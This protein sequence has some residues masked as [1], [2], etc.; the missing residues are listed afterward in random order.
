M[1][2]RAR[3]AVRPGER[4]F[5]PTGVPVMA[6][7][8]HQRVV[9]PRLAR[10]ELDRPKAVLVTRGVLHA[11]LEG[12]QLAQ[13]EVIDVGVEVRR[14][15]RVMGKIWIGV[16][17]REVRVLHARARGVDE[18]VAVGGGHPVLVL[19]HPVAAHAVGLLE[20]VEGDAA[21]VQCLDRRDPGGARADQANVRQHRRA[22]TVMTVCVRR[23]HCSQP[24]PSGA[25]MPG[26]ACLGGPSGPLSASAWP[27]RPASSGRSAPGSLAP[28]RR[29][30][31]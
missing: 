11:G 12:D 9:V 15:L 16:G 23:A 2:L 25:L 19:E 17:H 7:G 21:L 1:Q 6:V 27:A 10:I 5:G 8:D 18:Q 24:Y 26:P 4:R 22:H 20:A 31:R 3:E 14:D 28:L 30:A 29:L 13:A